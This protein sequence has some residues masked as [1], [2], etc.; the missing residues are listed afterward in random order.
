MSKDIIDDILRREGAPTNDKTDRGGR[1]A[2]GISEKS[3]PE[4]WKDGR[5]TEDEARAIYTR[6]YLKPFELVK[7]FPFYEQAVDFGVNSGPPLAITKIQ[8]IVGAEV[9]G[10]LGPDTVA[11]VSSYEGDLNKELAKS[12]IRMI[13]RLVSKN[14]S[15][16]KYINGWLNRAL[17]FI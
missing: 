2:F 7:E 12:R 9:D 5:V 14:P 3:N 15:Q 4:A 1:T 10:I 13:G 11:K 16:L 17:E 6:K 8:E